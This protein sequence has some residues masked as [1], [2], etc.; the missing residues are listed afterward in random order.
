MG[1]FSRFEEELYPPINE[2]A[3]LFVRLGM[4][5]PRLMMGGAVPTGEE[6][7]VFFSMYHTCT[8]EEPTRQHS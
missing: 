8:S 4:N 6:R 2:I 1:F 7:K 3:K 5:A